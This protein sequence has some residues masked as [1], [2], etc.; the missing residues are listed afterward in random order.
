MLGRILFVVASFATVVAAD[1]CDPSQFQGV[2]GFQLAG[3]ATISGRAQPVV[4][5]GRLVFDGWAGVTGI[6]SVSFTG[7]YL[8]NPVTGMYEAR[9]DCS[10]SWSLQDESV[11]HQHFAGT[12]TADGRRIQ[13]RQTDP[14]S[15]SQ[16]TLTKTADTCHDGDFQP[17]YR[18]TLSGSRINVDTGQVSGSVSATDTLERNGKQLTLRPASGNGASSSGSVEV[19]DD[20]FVQLHLAVPIAA[21]D[22]MEMNFRGMLVDGGRQLLGMAVDPGTAISLRLIAP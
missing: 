3:T 19:G 17:R 2:Y 7:L 15:P 14:G 13:F 11:N 12:M 1:V 6:S 5:V 10:A 4:S 20:C 22:P 9:P 18:F 8:G 21:A 16:G